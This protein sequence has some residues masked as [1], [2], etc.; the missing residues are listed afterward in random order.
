M[1]HL[2]SSKTPNQNAI[3][4][5]SQRWDRDKCIARQYLPGKGLQDFRGGQ[6]FVKTRMR[7]P[8][9]LLKMI[10]AMSPQPRV[11]LFFGFSPAAPC[12]CAGILFIQANQSLRRRS[13]CQA[14]ILMM[15]SKFKC[16]SVLR[17]INEYNCLK[18]AGYICR[19]IDTWMFFSKRKITCPG[20]C[21]AVL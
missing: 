6:A 18:E 15:Q 16:F 7:F 2:E 9:Y 3:F 17:R 13:M 14:N 5:H 21:S 11:R 20:K 12:R 4:L 19:I 8:A 1:V 10:S